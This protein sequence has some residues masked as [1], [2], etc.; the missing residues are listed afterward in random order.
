MTRN[1][2]DSLLEILKEIDENGEVIIARGQEQREVLSKLTK[3][4]RPYERFL[5]LPGRN[6]NV[7]AQIAETA[8]VLAGR[9]DLSF[10]SHYLPRASDFSDDGKTWRAAYGPRIRRWGGQID[11]VKEVVERLREDPF[12]KRAVASIFDPSSDFIETRDVP[13]NNWLQFI[14]REGKLDLHVTVRANDA[15][16]GFS[17]INFFEWSVL[18]EI[19]AC[20][21]GWELGTLS[22]YV[23]SFHVYARHYKVANRLRVLEGFRSPYEVGVPATRI[24]TTSD[25]LDDVLT[26]IFDAE[27]FAR[28]GSFAEAL[29]IEKNIA[30]P[31]F[32]RAATMLR[33]Y[34]AHLLGQE[35][36]EI[37]GIL[38]ELDDSDF[39]SAA[40]E[41]LGRAWGD[42]ALIPI[43]TGPQST[44]FKIFH[45]T[46]EYQLTVV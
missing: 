33:L 26:Q 1:I 20:S 14:Q 34:N 10:L 32:R 43:P 24:E 38:G 12:T 11:Q 6:N 2:T 27:S 19:V 46:R 23:G 42:Y 44:F 4:E 35:R 45:A 17:G 13:C 16:W 39:F 9:D 18:H 8:W 21:L 28:V 40:A 3:I 30:D 25:H 36:A 37:L 22:W 5:V 7:F 29:A 31:F 15:I 41:Y